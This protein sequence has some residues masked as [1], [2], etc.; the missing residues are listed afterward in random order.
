[1]DNEAYLPE[2]WATYT[3]RITLDSPGW[4]AVFRWCLPWYVFRYIYVIICGFGTV[5]RWGEGEIEDSMSILGK[6]PL[7]SQPP[8]ILD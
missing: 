7:S 3:H 1:M 8:K 2:I 4:A 5:K 6:K